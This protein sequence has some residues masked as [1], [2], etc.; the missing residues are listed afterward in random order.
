MTKWLPTLSPTAWV[1]TQALLTQLIG[2]LLFA[3]QA[4]LLG[5]KAFGLVAIVMAF[6]GICE[7]L[8]SD[9]S[10]ECLISIKR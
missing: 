5:P 8:M 7:M 9:A 3:I 6:I 1:T 2:L 4:P 10:A